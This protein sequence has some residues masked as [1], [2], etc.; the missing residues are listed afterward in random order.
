[1]NPFAWLTRLFAPKPRLRYG[2]N[3]PAL[4]PDRIYEFL[5]AVGFPDRQG[6]E[7]CVLALSYL[8]IVS[9]I[10]EGGNGRCNANFTFTGKGEPATVAK[11]KTAIE[12]AAQRHGGKLFITAVGDP[13]ESAPS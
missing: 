13:A 8:N 1:M 2:R 7:R 4:D 11:I 10:G 3:G 12:Q 5:F 6:A 9:K